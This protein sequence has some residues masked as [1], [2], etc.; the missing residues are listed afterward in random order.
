MK[1]LTYLAEHT[2]TKK[3][4][5]EAACLFVAVLTR[6]AL[7][8]GGPEVVLPVR[9]GYELV[10]VGIVAHEAGA[11]VLTHPVVLEVPAGLQDKQQSSRTLGP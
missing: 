4:N 7:D 8:T 11:G 5:E 6:A 2:T 9:V 10:Q 1:S 3:K